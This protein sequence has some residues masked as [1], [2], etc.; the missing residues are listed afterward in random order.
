MHPHPD[1]GTLPPGRD[2]VVEVLRR[3]GVDRERELVAEV[4]PPLE[5]RLGRLVGLEVPAEALLDEQPF[6]DGL[7]RAGRAEHALEPRAPPALAHHDEVAWTGVAETVAIERERQPGREERLADDEL[8][9]PGDLDD[10]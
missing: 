4:D 5:A 3:L 6:Q 7:D 9:P 8:S 2:R 10:D 1:P